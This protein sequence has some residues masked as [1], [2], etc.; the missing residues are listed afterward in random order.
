M[1]PAH[2]ISPL[3]RA[4]HRAAIAA[5]LACPPLAAQ[6][7][8]DQT[9][10]TAVEVPVQVFLDG[11]PVRGLGVGD[12][13][14]FEGKKRQQITGF[15][16]VD[17][18]T[19]DPRAPVDALP[20]A[21]RRHVLFFFDLSNAT[22]PSLSRAQ[23]AGLD[24]LHQALHPTDLA[25]VAVY[26]P[27]SGARLL[28]G[29]TSDRRQLAL[30]LQTL[31][32]PQ[33]IDRVPD[34]LGLVLG[35]ARAD[36]DILERM[37]R[38]APPARAARE[39]DQQTFAEMYLE[40]LNDL[41]PLEARA[42]SEAQRQRAQTMVRAIGDVAALLQA[43]EGSKHV[44][45]LS[46]GLDGALLTGQ[47]EETTLDEEQREGGFLWRVDSQQRFGS[48]ELQN[49]LVRVL[50]EMRRADAIVHSIDIGGLRVD[51]RGISGDVG[52]VAADA[53]RGAADGGQDTLLLMASETGGRLFRNSND[54]AAGMLELF[55]RTTVTYLLSYQ[56]SAPGKGGFRPLRV[57]VA[58]V[59]RR[60]QV[61]HRQGYV[62]S[63]EPAAGGELSERLRMAELV[64]AGRAG[65]ALAVRAA[66]VALP[67]SGEEAYVP[68]VV[69]VPGVP[70]LL[71]HAG[72]LL[73]VELDLYVFAA[74]GAV[75]E[76]ASQMV[77]MNL[78]KVRDALRSSG[79]KVYADVLLPPGNY[80]VRAVV[81]NVQTGRWGIAATTV[82][83]PDAGGGPPGALAAIFLEPR[84]GWLLVRAQDESGPAQPYPFVVGERPLTPATLPTLRGGEPAELWLLLPQGSGDQVS[85]SLRDGSGTLRPAPLEPLAFS[86]R[87]GRRVVHARLA[88]PSLPAG[89]YVLEL[90]L[91]GGGVAGVELPFLVQR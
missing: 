52:A 18:A 1:P 85:G 38:A 31:G 53:L 68:I 42:S 50:G 30:A 70:L 44:L 41:A 11:Q 65:G 36:V 37:P 81:R 24:V 25:A 74:D 12:F 46:E 75:V 39:E 32:S 80:G 16:V 5:V 79:L 84:A 51:G 27:T 55:G 72:D 10:V 2:R 54:L 66:T 77:G 9:S 34:R 43:V 90:S 64:V 71:G 6:P 83:A 7:F 40:N 14:L 26:S 48:S 23:A 8:Q 28:L 56:P 82:V 13:A 61:T 4:A 21:A 45:F 29:F 91:P 49:E 19:L 63:A 15:E 17:L 3:R 88:P 78:Q 60:A 20:A 87:G 47:V 62:P 59:P 86:E 89:E 35:E 22:P 33:L 73:T 57:E 76:R 69:D 67:T 58:G